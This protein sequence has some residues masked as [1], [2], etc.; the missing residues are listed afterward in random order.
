MGES[1]S[2]ISEDVLN[3]IL[4]L[5]R[6]CPITSE[7]FGKIF[8]IIHDQLDQDSEHPGFSEEHTPIDRSQEW[9]EIQ[10]QEHNRFRKRKSQ[11]FKESQI[12]DIDI[13]RMESIY[14]GGP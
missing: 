12:E 3:Q 14:S 5:F 8:R 2:G 9:G 6:Q 10:R 13:S 11:R 7:D 4:V 1:G